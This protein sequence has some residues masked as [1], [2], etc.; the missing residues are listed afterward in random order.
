MRDLNGKYAIV[1][2]GGKGIGAAIVK[3]FLLEGAAGVAIFDYD[4][5]LAKETA[6]Q[7]G[8]NILVCK[9]DVSNAEQVQAAV[10]KTLSAFDRIDILVNNAGITRDAMFHKMTDEEW[11][12]VININL[13]GPYNCCKYVVPHMRARGYGKIINISSSSANGNAGQANYSATKAGLI[14]FTKTLAKEL[15]AKGITSNAIAPAMIDTDMMRAVPEQ[16]LNIYLQSCPTRR[17]GTVDELASA[18]LFLASDD[19]SFVNGAVLPV[20]GG[21]FT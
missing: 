11:G 17:F 8:G 6:G 5:A 2:G 21:M 15:A 20:N 9:C 3:R 19:S 4:E 1:T 14:G 12:Q 16:L 13:N 10:E 7:L 18:A